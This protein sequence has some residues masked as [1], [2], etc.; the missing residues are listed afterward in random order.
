MRATLNA[1][2]RLAILDSQ[3]GRAGDARHVVVIEDKR[4][5]EL[6]ERASGQR[7]TRSQWSAV[8]RSAPRRWVGYEVIV[9]RRI[10]RPA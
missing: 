6:V 9:T 5:G 3:Y 7:Y 8:V 4:T 10:V 2:A 1:A